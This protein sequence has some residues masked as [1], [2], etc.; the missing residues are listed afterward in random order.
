[1]KPVVKFNIP[2]ENKRN[3]PMSLF[4][5]GQLRKLNASLAIQEEAAS[6]ADTIFLHSA[7]CSVFFPYREKDTHD[8]LYKKLNNCELILTPYYDLPQYSS[9]ENT[10]PRSHYG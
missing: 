3:L 2:E 1:M 6:S 9:G 8:M 7:L 5:K 4:T 10:Q